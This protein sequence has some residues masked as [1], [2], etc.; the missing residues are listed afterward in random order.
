LALFFLAAVWAMTATASAEPFLCPVVGD[1]VKNADSRNGD[2]G[3]EA[4]E[5]PV[6]TS[7][8]PGNNQAG[9]NSNPK[10]HNTDGPGNPN[11]GPGHN[12]NFSPIWP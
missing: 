11:A 7:F 2:H 10:A 8:F 4:I 3:V 12:P 5:P 1:G 9:V 6:G